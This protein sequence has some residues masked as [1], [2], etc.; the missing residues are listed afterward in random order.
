MGECLSP[1]LLSNLLPSST[2]LS[3]APE[4]RHE[5]LPLQMQCPTQKMIRSAMH[6]SK[7]LS[8]V[9]MFS[10]ASFKI[11]YIDC[12]FH[13]I[14]FFFSSRHSTSH[15]ISKS[16]ESVV[17]RLL[18]LLLSKMEH[19]HGMSFPG[20]CATI[21]KTRFLESHTQNEKSK[22][23]TWMSCIGPKYLTRRPRVS[24]PFP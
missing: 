22:E 1:V 16:E 19:R 4:R 5:K 15:P 2:C 14:F 21:R 7:S 17:T 12:L 24:P 18:P 6:A 10:S 3:P 23:T 20:I 11:V 8:Q 13:L 9:F